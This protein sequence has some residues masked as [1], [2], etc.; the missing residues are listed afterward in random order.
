MAT[1]LRPR[2]FQAENKQ[3][4]RRKSR[5]TLIPEH[6]SS[7]WSPSDPEWGAAVD[8]QFALQDEAHG[9]FDADGPLSESSPKR[10]AS[11]VEVKSRKSVSP[12][13]NDK[14]EPSPSPGVEIVKEPPAEKPARV[15]R[16]ETTPPTQPFRRTRA[17]RPQSPKRAADRR[18]RR[19]RSAQPPTP[20][21]EKT[22]KMYLHLRRE[23]LEAPWKFVPR[24]RLVLRFRRVDVDSP[25]RIV[26]D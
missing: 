1:T 24:P 18:T 13:V 12:S 19:R 21:P 6:Y 5:L 20:V 23:N 25:W 16:K 10:C 17:L 15:K 9:I 22:P 4:C 8:Y 2:P 3:D 14:S 26:R 11:A 7:G